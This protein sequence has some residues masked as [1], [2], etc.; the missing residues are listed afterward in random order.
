MSGDGAVMV[1][2]LLLW[3]GCVCG[4]RRW[5]DGALAV[6][7]DVCFKVLAGLACHGKMFRGFAVGRYRSSFRPPDFVAYR[8]MLL[9]MLTKRL[10]RVEYIAVSLLLLVA[11]CKTH[12]LGLYNKGVDGGQEVRCGGHDDK[13]MCSWRACGR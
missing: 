5:V 12:S 11:V 7:S 9:G 1:R 4:G 8:R 3:R 13:G 10:F 6:V 2:W